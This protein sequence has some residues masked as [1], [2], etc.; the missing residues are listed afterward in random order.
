[1]LFS[2]Y[3]IYGKYINLVERITCSQEYALSNKYSTAYALTLPLSTNAD[4]DSKYTHRQRQLEPISIA[5]TTYPVCH[6]HTSSRARSL[7]RSLRWKSG[8][9][10]SIEQQ[11]PW[12]SGPVV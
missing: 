7:L 9:H 3:F 4:H 11:Q 12:K 10:L 1:M 5:L 2:T 8:T 6:T